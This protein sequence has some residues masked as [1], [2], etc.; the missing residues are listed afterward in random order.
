M[1][2]QVTDTS[3]SLAIEMYT[4]LSQ[5]YLVKL[6]DITTAYLK[7]EAIKKHVDNR[8]KT[9]AARKTPI[10]SAFELSN[11]R[12]GYYANY[13]KLKKVYTDSDKLRS[14]LMHGYKFLDA[15]RVAK[16]S[17]NQL[18]LV[19]VDKLENYVHSLDEA[20][21]N[22]D[23]S[24]R[25]LKHRSLYY[26]HLIVENK[27]KP[28]SLCQLLRS[29]CGYRPNVTELLNGTDEAALRD[30]VESMEVEAV[31]L[32]QMDG[33]EHKDQAHTTTEKSGTEVQSDLLCA[34]TQKNEYVNLPSIR[35]PSNLKFRKKT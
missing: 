33:K 4:S 6:G 8:Y 20:R 25:A 23:D 31:L 29:P 15:D 9:L 32:T 22:L 30:P 14:A 5:Q 13:R 16:I 17:N 27:G 2:T 19:Q 11:E 34:E 3:A 7:V 24:L 35:H 10:P 12:A 28:L 18:T 1:A 26:F 21:E